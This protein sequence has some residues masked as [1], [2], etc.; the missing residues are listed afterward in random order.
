MPS[1]VYLYVKDNQ[2]KNGK[3]ELKNCLNGTEVV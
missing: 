3:K 2:L 1:L